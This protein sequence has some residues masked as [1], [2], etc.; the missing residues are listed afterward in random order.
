MNLVSLTY[1]L[2]VFLSAHCQG[3]RSG[4]T[5]STRR[6]HQT[7]WFIAP[8]TPNVV[9]VPTSSNLLA[10]S[11]EPW[12]KPCDDDETLAKSSGPFII[13]T[14]AD[15]QVHLLE[16]ATGNAPFSSFSALSDSPVLS[17]V[18][19]LEGRYVLLTNMS[20][21]LLLQHGSRTLDS[22]KDHAKYAIKVIAHRDRNDPS[23]FW[24]ATAGWDSSVVLYCLHTPDEDGGD[25]PSVTLGEPVA[26]IKTAT[27][28]ESILFVPHIDTDEL[29]LLVS[30]RD[31]SYIYYYQ[32]ESLSKD[33]RDRNEEANSDPGSSSTECR[34]LGRQ[35]LAPHSNAWVAFSPAHMALS[36]HD[37]GLLAVA[38]STLPHLKVILVRLLFPSDEAEDKTNTSISDVE[39]TQA[40]QALEALALQNKE[41][42]A[43]LI[44]ANTFAPQTA[45][46]TP[47]VAWRPD[48]SGLWVNGD[49]GVVRGIETRTGKVV[50]MLKNGHEVGC[51]VRSVWAGYVDV[52]QD[53][54]ETV[55]EEWV[56]SGGFDK[57][58]IIWQV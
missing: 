6:N 49:D 19:I 58:L 44:Q 37:P 25:S 17:Y 46:S 14:G 33:A 23:T 32:V 57:R 21:Q 12:Q 45:Y 29:N 8:K 31:S 3:G 50:S 2:G 10:A 55:R 42:A 54:K 18:S 34:L 43:I 28:P 13:S 4:S 1:Q 41:D 9:S 51:K 56:I 30:R 15:R 7:D 52:P 20:G 35:N 40:S 36:P 24:V 48:G 39:V 53:G 26:R 38:T 5:D 27:N 11:V 22:R 16:T 47:Q